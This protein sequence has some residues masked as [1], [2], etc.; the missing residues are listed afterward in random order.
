MIDAQA[1]ET[2]I[3]TVVERFYQIAEQDPVIGPVF[4][5]KVGDWPGHLQVVRDF[6]SQILLGTHRY[7]GDA[8]KAHDGMS[9]EPHHFDRW[10]A[11]LAQVA[12]EELPP[13]L[14]AKAMAQATHMRQCLQSGGGGPH[15]PHLIKLPLPR[16]RRG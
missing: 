15:K 9:L 7:Q 5:D 14:A 3:A 12:N 13:V 11:I 10:L 1:L 2:K 6:W 8:F 16:A 4:A